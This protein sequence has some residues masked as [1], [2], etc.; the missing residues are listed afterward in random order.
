MM[1]GGASGVTI[2]GTDSATGTGFYCVMSATSTLLPAAEKILY[3]AN[4]GV[5]VIATRD[6]G[7][8]C[9]SIQIQAGSNYLD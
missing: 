4:N 6:A 2:T 9:T 7:G 8:I 1:A 5:Y 3:A